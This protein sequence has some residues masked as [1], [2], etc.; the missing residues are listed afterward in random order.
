MED[1]KETK[2]QIL[3]E[4]EVPEGVEM[5]VDV[6]ELEGTG[7]KVVISYIHSSAR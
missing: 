6:S 1:F 7:K 4:T 3:L 5:R 2:E